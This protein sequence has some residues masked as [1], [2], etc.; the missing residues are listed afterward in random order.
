[1][2]EKH[3]LIKEVVESTV[4]TWQSDESLTSHPSSQQAI[5]N[6]RPVFLLKP[7]EQRH[8]LGH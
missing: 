5:N 2:P 6:S 1:M 8:Q 3:S 4:L 7:G